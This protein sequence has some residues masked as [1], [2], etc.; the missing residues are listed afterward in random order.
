MLMEQKITD[1]GSKN[2]TA[3]KTHGTNQ[4]ES[5][6]KFQHRSSSSGRTVS[7]DTTKASILETSKHKFISRIIDQTIK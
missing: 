5:G 1:G 3:R 6:K 7:D 4:L 2:S